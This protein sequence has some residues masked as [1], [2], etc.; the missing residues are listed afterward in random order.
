LGRS[1]E[2]APVN[3]PA[4]KE[5]LHGFL[6]RLRSTE[7]AI[8]EP[9]FELLQDQA[10]V[11]VDVAAYRHERY[12]PI[13]HTESIDVFTREI[14]WLHALGIVNAPESQVPN[15]SACEWGELVVEEDDVVMWSHDVYKIHFFTIDTDIYLVK[16]GSRRDG[17]QS[18]NGMLS[19]LD[20]SDLGTSEIGAISA[21]LDA[22]N[23]R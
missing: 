8:W 5:L 23:L 10:G 1:C 16:K 7:C 2:D 14:G 15:H 19:P 18:F 12:T 17:E 13:F 6:V 22:V 20:Q 11:A 3:G 21:D 4:F 9:L